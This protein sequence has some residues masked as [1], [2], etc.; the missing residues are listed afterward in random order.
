MKDIVNATHCPGYAVGIA[1][2]SNIKFKLRI[3]ETLSHII[4]FFFVT[5]EDT[6][7]R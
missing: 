1:Y 5:A 7:L 2:I 3:S 4:L 6:N